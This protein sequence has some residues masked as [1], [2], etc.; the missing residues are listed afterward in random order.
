MKYYLAMDFGAS[1]GRGMLGCFDGE[2]LHLEELHRFENGPVSGADGHLYWDAEKLFREIVKSL[3]VAAGRGIQLESIGVDTWGVDYGLLDAD[4]KLLGMP[5]HYRDS[6]TDGQ[7]EAVFATVP[8]KDVFGATGIQFM[9]LNTLFQLYAEREGDR[10]AKAKQLLFMPDLFNYMLTGE[11]WCERS[12]ASTSQCYDPRKHDWADE[13]LQG[14][15]LE[16]VPW[17]PLVDSGTVLGPVKADLAASSGIGPVP[18]VA[19]AGH[20]T[21]S[22]VVAVPATSKDF[23]Y[24]SSGTWSLMGAELDAP[25][26]DDRSH[27]RNFTNEI[28]Y[29]RKVRFLKNMTGMWLQQECRRYWQEAGQDYSWKELE[30]MAEAAAPFRSVINSDDPLFATPGKMPEKIAAW[31]R[32]H[33]QP[34]P[35]EPGAVVRA[36]F[37]GLALRYRWVVERLEE[38]RGKRVEVL[39]VVGGGS[40]NDLL[41][42]FTASATGKTVLAGPMEATAL[43]NIAVQMLGLGH[44]KDLAAARKL[45]AASFPTVSYEPERTEDWSAAAERFAGLFG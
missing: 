6:R 7:M 43:G 41:N 21:A 45:V 24:L 31:C 17:A 18:V 19:V 23:V 40:A 20:D 11:A 44:V 14:L 32:A 34:V 5:F 28:G 22:A 13:L 9:Q 27:E 42:R 1:S 26:I 39:H 25:L 35:E 36:I 12:I 30:A 38:L 15:G 37:E 3:S 8:S 4:G 29:G 16:N 33:G 2:K 10:L